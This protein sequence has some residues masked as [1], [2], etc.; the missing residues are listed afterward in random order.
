MNI[1]SANN[2]RRLCALL[3][4]PPS[5]CVLSTPGKS[6]YPHECIHNSG[7][8]TSFPLSWLSIPVGSPIT[9]FSYPSMIE[10]GSSEMKLSWSSGNS[11]AFSSWRNVDLG[12]RGAEHT[13]DELP[14][15]LISTKVL[16]IL[17][18]INIDLCHAIEI[19]NGHV[20]FLGHCLELWGNVDLVELCQVAIFEGHFI[21][22][23]INCQWNM[24]K[25]INGGKE[26]RWDPIPGCISESSLGRSASSR[27]EREPEIYQSQ[28]CL[29]KKDSGVW[30]HSMSLSELLRRGKSHW[31]RPNVREWDTHGSP[32]IMKLFIGDVRALLEEEKDFDVGRLKWCHG[33]GGV[34]ILGIFVLEVFWSER[35]RELWIFIFRR[36]LQEKRR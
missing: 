5:N 1:I 35:G 32:V 2:F 15:L 16:P 30:E 28:H 3:H 36:C 23:Y 34:R 22:P 14:E 31:K 21:P 11:S 9:K 8:T 6:S 10:I 29:T 27:R 4:H 20:K 26:D 13:G 19:D 12:K 18:I 17:H 25:Q 33:R 7:L 24:F